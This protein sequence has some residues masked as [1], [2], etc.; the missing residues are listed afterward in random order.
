MAE[1]KGK[2]GKEGM[3]SC[4]SLVTSLLAN[5]RQIQNFTALSKIIEL[6]NTYTEIMS[7][8]CL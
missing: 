5:I 6:M 3:Y 4:A 8:L 1:A 2:K 7:S